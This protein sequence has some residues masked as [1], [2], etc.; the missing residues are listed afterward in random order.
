MVSVKS[1]SMKI[2]DNEP[3]MLIIR[4]KADVVGDAPSLDDTNSKLAEENCAQDIEIIGCPALTDSG[5]AASENV[6][7]DEMYQSAEGTLPKLRQSKVRDLCMADIMS[8]LTL[9]MPKGAKTGSDFACSS[10]STADGEVL[11]ESRP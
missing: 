5:A 8:M 10:A 6:T 4:K 1:V 2:K 3:T 9:P 7:V 11:D